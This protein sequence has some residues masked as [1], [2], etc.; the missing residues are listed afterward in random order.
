LHWGLGGKE[1]TGQRKQ[2]QQMGPNGNGHFVELPSL[3]WFEK[4]MQIV[5]KWQSNNEKG[6]QTIN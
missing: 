4:L 1:E 5:I 3:G 2:I 6:N